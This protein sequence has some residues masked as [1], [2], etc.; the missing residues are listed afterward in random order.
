ME[1]QIVKEANQRLLNKLESYIDNDDSLINM[2]KNFVKGNVHRLILEKDRISVIKD[3]AKEIL[4]DDV[5]DIF[6]LDSNF[7]VAKIK[8]S[9]SNKDETP[10]LYQTVNLETKRSFH[11]ASHDLETQ[12]LYTMQWKYDVGS[13]SDFVYFVNRM[14]NKND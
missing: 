1:N 3:A 5:Y 13:N 6:E 7:V 2:Q 10:F 14:L 8:N 11:M 9:F 4:K 12:I